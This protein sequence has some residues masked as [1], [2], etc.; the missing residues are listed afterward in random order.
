MKASDIS[1]S[2]MDEDVVINLEMESIEN[3]EKTVEKAG[4]VEKHDEEPRYTHIHF[5]Y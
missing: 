5:D 3:T 2:D 1:E 4:N